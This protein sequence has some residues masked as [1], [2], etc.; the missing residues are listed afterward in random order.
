M[1]AGVTHAP[2]RIPL[3]GLVL[4]LGFGKPQ[5]K[6]ILVPLVGILLHALPDAHCQ[7]LLVVVIED[8][9]LFQRGGI[10][11]NIAPGNIGAPLVKEGADHVY[12]LR[13]A[14][15]GGLHHVG[16]LDIQLVAVGEKRVGVE[17]GDLHHRLVLPAG[18]L[19]H[20]VLAGIG[21]GGQVAHIGDIHDT[22]YVIAQITQG[23]FQHIL[24]NI[25]AEVADVGVVVYRRA[26]GVHFHLVRVVGYKQLFFVGQRII[27]IHRGSPFRNIHIICRYF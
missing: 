22:L 6:V 19:E 27:Q 10:K 21:V 2:G 14:V 13:N 18:A 20:F 4:K 25:G 15:R 24:H 3:E 11:V 5:D 8:I 9:V 7:I 1:P 12:I 16:P 26:A 17:L 23:F